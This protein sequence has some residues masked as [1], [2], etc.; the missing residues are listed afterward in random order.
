M[1]LSIISFSENGRVLA[2]EVSRR[3]RYCEVYPKVLDLKA[4]TKEQFDTHR[5][6]LFIGACGI[7]VRSIAPFLESKLTDSPVLVMDEKGKYVIPILSGHVGGA[8]ALAREIAACMG[9]EA[10]ITTATDLNEKFAVDVFATDNGFSIQNKEGIEKISSRILGGGQVT[11]AID[12]WSAEESKSYLKEKNGGCPG[13][14][15]PIDC[16]EEETADILISERVPKS[17]VLWLKPKLYILGMG[18]KRGKE[19]ASLFA[20]VSECFKQQKLPM[21]EICGLASIDRKQ[22]EEGLLALA[23]YLRVPFFTYPEEQLKMLQGQF[24]ASAFVES[25][26]GVDNVCERAALLA[27]REHGKI[28]LPKTASE[29][30]TLAI[31][32]RDWRK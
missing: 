29:G 32:R 21:E 25:R 5:A 27:C 28:I 31:V 15:L 14:V 23:D 9:A 11:F 26:V 2:E 13:E 16:T 10:V 24:S 19:F 30:M 12:G 1:K 7:A 6:I 18:C 17:A 3:R 8:N 20:F 22:K 4:W